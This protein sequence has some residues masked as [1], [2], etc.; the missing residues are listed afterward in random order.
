MANGL[1]YTLAALATLVFVVGMVSH[2]RLWL[3]AL[4]GDQEGGESRAIAV[5]RGIPHALARRR[6][7][8]AW[9]WEGVLQRQIWHESRLRWLIHIGLSWGFT[10]LFFATSADLLIRRGLLPLTKD[11]P[12]FAVL[13]ELGGLLLVVGVALALYRRLVMR[14]PHLRTEAQD[15]LIL[16]WLLMLG[17]GGYLAEAARFGVDGVPSTVARWSFVG[18]G[19]FRG[20]QAAGIDP[21]GLMGLAWWSHAVAS[22]ALIAALPYTKLLHIFTAPLVLTLETGKTTPETLSQVPAGWVP[23]PHVQQ[24]A[25]ML[26]Q[27]PHIDPLAEG[28]DS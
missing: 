25:N 11:T 12:W 22:L 4:A 13:N 14:P 2:V 19:L 17:F 8:Q 27:V 15:L 28:G 16:V 5:L 21:A 20:L 10:E 9:F 1:F 24:I 7:W 3:G 6:T 23:S 18:Y 26:S